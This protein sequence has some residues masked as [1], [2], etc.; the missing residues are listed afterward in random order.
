VGL[1]EILH[2]AYITADVHF[3]KTM[4]S[5][6]NPI[7]HKDRL[8]SYLQLINSQKRNLNSTASS[9]RSQM[10]PTNI[11]KENV[12]RKST[13]ASSYSL[14]SKNPKSLK[15]MNLLRKNELMSLQGYEIDTAFVEMLS[16]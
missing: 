1:L 6:Q 9:M 8:L 15:G 14:H 12:T 7:Q 4:N 2:E 16:S 13:A 3:A 10:L 5:N 11:L